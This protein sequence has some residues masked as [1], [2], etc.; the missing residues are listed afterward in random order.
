MSKTSNKIRR[1]AL[2]GLAAAMA[3]GVTTVAP[4]ARADEVT[5]TVFSAPGWDYANVRPSPDTGGQPIGRV[6]AGQTAEL[7]CYQYGGEAKGPYGSSTLWYKV[8]GYGSGWIADS[9]LSTGSDLP[10]TGMC[11]EDNQD[12]TPTVPNQSPTSMARVLNDPEVEYVNG[13]IGPTTKYNTLKVYPANSGFALECWTKGESVNGPDG[14][15]SERWYFTSDKTWVSAAY[16]SIDTAGST[17]PDCNSPNGTSPTAG[18]RVEHPRTWPKTW[19]VRYD[20]NDSTVADSLYQHYHKN[21][22]LPGV[23]A[24]IGWSYF[25][26]RS[27]FKAQAYKTRVGDYRKIT[28]EDTLHFLGFDVYRAIGAF[29]IYRTDSS[30][31]LVYDYYDFDYDFP[32][33]KFAATTGRAQEFHVYSAGCYE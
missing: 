31:F 16:L 19:D 12:S 2:F 20:G 28:R 8:K 14:K 24:R 26:D 13:R 9:M 15:A 33:E 25:R 30:C 32:H 5:A 18:V 17:I 10:V 27:W 1:F 11:P 3:T 4:P 22:S 7:T 21:D 6:Q 23:D 29:T